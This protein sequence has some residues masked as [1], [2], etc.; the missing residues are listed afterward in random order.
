MDDANLRNIIKTQDTSNLLFHIRLQMQLESLKKCDLCVTES[1][2]FIIRKNKILLSTNF[3]NLEV[4]QC[5]E[6]HILIIKLLEEN[7]DVQ[8]AKNND[9]KDQKNKKVKT[10]IGHFKK[11]NLLNSLFLNLQERI[12]IEKDRLIKNNEVPQTN[13]NEQ[14][15]SLPEKETSLYA[16]VMAGRTTFLIKSDLKGGLSSLRLNIINKLAE[17]LSINI[18]KELIKMK[19]Y[20][21]INVYMKYKK[22]FY[23]IDHDADLYSGAAFSNNRVELVIRNDGIE[24]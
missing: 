11:L 24:K 18:K 5:K 8:Y 12:Q 15:K 1:R 22:K 21:N 14:K 4:E 19:K 9:N 7:T 2:L 23:R 17:I 13:K 6:K 3:I 16:T 10:F 20:Q